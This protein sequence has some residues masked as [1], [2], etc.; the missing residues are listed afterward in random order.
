[1][2]EQL[3]ENDHNTWAKKKKLVLE[4][5]GTESWFQHLLYYF[6][7]YF[8]L[9]SLVLSSFLVNI[10]YN[11]FLF[12]GKGGHSMLVPY[13]TLTAKEKTKF[14]ERAQDILKFLHL[15]GYTVWR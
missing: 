15:N 3:A 1:M 10:A 4:S 7:Y 5:R 8:L 9:S 14:R 11:P 2:A 6:S 13:D 12:P